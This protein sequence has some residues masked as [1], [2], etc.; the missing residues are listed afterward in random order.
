MYG[1]GLSDGW[2]CLYIATGMEKRYR[3]AS[4]HFR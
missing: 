4:D 2:Y 1:L 3:Y